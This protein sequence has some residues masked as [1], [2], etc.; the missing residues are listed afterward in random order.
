MTPNAA[1]VYQNLPDNDKRTLELCLHLIVTSPSTEY[2]LGLLYQSL[3]T[4]YETGYVVGVN[5]ANVG[6]R[7]EA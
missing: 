5:D 2:G 3:R 6:K 1:D 4:M 7:N